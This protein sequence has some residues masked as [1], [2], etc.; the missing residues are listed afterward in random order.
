MLGGAGA[1]IAA[2]VLHLASRFAL[3]PFVVARAGLEAYGYWSLLFLALGLFGVHRMGFV[4]A[5]VS[6]AARAFALG[7]QRGAERVL[8][9][10]STL[11]GIAGLV[12]IGA[13]LLLATPLAR[14]LGAEGE[15]LAPATHA[16][17]ITVVAICASLVLGGWQSALEAQHEIARVK[18][19]EALA[20]LTESALIALFVAAGW[21]LVGL[22][23]AYALRLLLPVPL[24]AR[25]VARITP[26][27]CVLPGQLS[28]HAA[29]SVLGFGVTMQLSGALHLAIAAIERLSL[30]HGGSLA[31]AGVFE[32]SR[33]LVS[34]AAALPSHALGPL[35]P[36][37]A[38]RQALD[39]D[40][41]GLASV[42]RPATRAIAL[43]AAVPLAFLAATSGPF[44]T[45]WIG[46]AA[47]GA[48]LAVR[49]LVVGAYV[50]LCTGPATAVL[51]GLARPRLE[52]A[53]TALWLGLVAVLAPLAT[54]RWGLAGAAAATSLA[55]G[56]AAGALLVIGLPR[57]GV[58]LRQVA[59]DVSLPALCAAAP[60]A[61]FA[62]AFDPTGLSR[63]ELA[64]HLAAGGL[65]V[66]LG[67]SALA[68]A[69]LFQSRERALFRAALVALLRRFVP[70]H[71]RLETL[72]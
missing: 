53:Y 5:S 17:R 22:A 30:V 12:A 47:P 9:T 8:R 40:G 2:Q 64:S 66:A 72:R 50:H 38:E 67:A 56:V 13:T 62:L 48:A 31:L 6:F 32:V 59:A 51:R 1:G 70:A 61:L 37:A 34:F 20:S 3:A 63:L 28:R 14:W 21:G 35:V 41:S 69:L 25:A 36:A 4:S 10:T 42:L 39:G 68:Y 60:A 26:G 18:R 55:Q 15:L 43:L 49:V 54:Q 11:A 71:A 27:L 19:T 58:S 44:L 23:S 57:L 16:M 52:I 65:A 7:D 33:K 29:K 46:E 24:H 45:A